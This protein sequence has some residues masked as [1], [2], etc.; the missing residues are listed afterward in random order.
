MNRSVN[1]QLES[2]KN[3][4]AEGSAS[5]GNVALTQ[6]N[7]LLSKMI[8]NTEGAAVALQDAI[9]RYLAGEVPPNL[10]TALNKLNDRLTKVIDANDALNSP[11][12]V[13]RMISRDLGVKFDNSIRV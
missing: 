6:I 8:F 1:E 13:V 5:S 3:R 10:K 7:D 11:A 9:D 12:S 2:L 4:L